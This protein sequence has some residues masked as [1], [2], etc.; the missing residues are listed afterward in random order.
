MRNLA[1]KTH[2]VRAKHFI[3]ACC[4]I[5][6]A[7]LLL[8]ANKQVP[9]GLGNQNDNVGRYFMEHL[10]IKSAELWLNKP[11]VLKL[12]QWEWQVTKARA[13]LAISE[14]M[15]RNY[16][17][18]NGTASLIPLDIARQQ[19]AFIDIWTADTAETKR[20]MAR[21]DK[22]D[23]HGVKRYS[24]FQLFTRVEQAPNANSRV[25]LDTEKDALDVPRA[26]LHWE[27]TSLEKHSLRSIYKVIGQQMGSSAAGRVRLMEYLRDEA[28]NSWP[29][30]T[31]GGWH[32]M[33][34]TRMSVEP[35]KG[36]V[37]ANCKV[38][39]LANLYMAGAS[40]YVTAGAPNPT[41]T[42]VAL[43]IRLADHIKQK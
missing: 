2:T 43:T 18:L 17:I 3:I 4:S 36:V 34:T 12:Y 24:S 30:F 29:S 27:L 32:H 11:D 10:E 40:C 38:H 28:D 20:N 23:K 14:E 1:G 37:D 22:L 33:G 21:M 42:L 7:R 6:N 13:E 19:P 41:L 35:K 8:A 5:Q 39:E 9:K 25:T 16:R 31:G 15:Q 26:M